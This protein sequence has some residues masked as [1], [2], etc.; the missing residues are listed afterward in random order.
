MASRAGYKPQLQHCQ[1]DGKDE[2][3]ANKDVCLRV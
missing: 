1:M 3:K 2:G